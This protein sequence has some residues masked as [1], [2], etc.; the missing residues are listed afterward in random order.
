MIDEKGQAIRWYQEPYMWLVVS[1]PLTAVIAGMVILYFAIE[2][3]D[4][5]VVDDYYKRGLEV[6]KVLERDHK[7]AEYELKANLEIAR[8]NP[9]FNIILT[10]NKNFIL[11]D[12]IKV[13]FL[14]P[15]RK[16]LDHQLVLKKGHDNI[17]HGPA[18]ELMRGKWYVQIETVNWRLFMNY[19]AQ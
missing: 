6:N 13:S 16:G 3:N 5:L 17:Y 2:S 19:Y 1:L 10:G 9:V 4:G 15:T 14:H 18:P 8:N 7:A 12:K 11:P